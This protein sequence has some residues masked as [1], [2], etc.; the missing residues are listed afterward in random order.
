MSNGSPRPGLTRRTAL[1]AAGAT[2]LSATLATTRAAEGST[3]RVAYPLPVATLDPAKFRVGGLEYNYAHCV[4][5]RL[6][7]QDTKL[8]VIP[9]LAQSWEASEDLKVWTFHLRPGVKFH[10]G[11]PLDAADILFTYKRLMDKENASVLRAALGVVEKIEAV[12]PMTVRFTLSS[13]YSDLAAV[14]A[15]YQAQILTESAMDTLTTKPVGTGPFRFVEYRPGDQLVVEKNPDYFVPGSPKVDRVI[16]RIIPEYTTSVA[17]LESGAIDLIYDLPPE[18]IDQLKNS[19]VARVEEVAC[20]SW[21]GIILNNAFKPFDD[22]RVREAFIKIVDRQA[23]TDIAMFGHGT[24][25]V[26]PI[27]P[28][29]PFF[30]ADLLTPPDIP[31]AKKLLAEAGYPNGFPLE[32]II[33]TGSPWEE[34]LG[35]AFRDAAK[36][37]GVTVS[38]RI[39][40]GDK[41]DAEME[42]KVAFS[43]D[44]FFGRPTPD[45]MV[46]AWYHSSGSWNNT[47]WHYSNPEVD[48]ILTAARST[49]DKAEQEK[50]YG[51]FQ[52]IVAKDGPGC[53]VF[54][55][56]FACGVSKKV[57]NFVGSPQMWVDINNVSLS[58]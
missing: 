5:N 3:L 30:R 18:Q 52:E 37:I 35:T 9:E 58:A 38:L 4:F 19:K 1:A 44:G 15:Q 10:N 8:Q 47:L 20:G 36:Q 39:V 27:P 31:G 7:A 28:T 25:T 51:R 26:T 12:D 57:Q 32:M 14:T 42:G 40:P 55:R 21:E 49:G 33:A 13:P 53:L 50:L 6:T 23:F 54:V 17:G 2:A 11:K 43:V 46:Y 45:T 24:P 29:H 48:K 34:R 16:M 22:P 41:F 56:N